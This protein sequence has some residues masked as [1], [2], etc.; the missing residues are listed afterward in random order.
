MS[1]AEQR[2]QTY[3]FRLKQTKNVQRKI[4]EM[5]RNL[6]DWID[7]GEGWQGSECAIQLTGWAKERRCIILRRPTKKTPSEKM[8]PEKSGDEFD[9]IEQV[10]SRELY[11]YAVLIT[12]DEESIVALA[13]L[14]RERADCENVFDEIK[15]QW[16]WGGFMTQDLK[17][18]RIIARLIALVYNWWNIFA[19]LARPDQHMEAITSRPLLL[20]AVG[21]LVKT[22][23]QR[24]LHLTSSHAQANEIRLALNRIGQFFNDLSRTAEQLSAEARW[25]VILSAAF[26]K[27]LRGKILHPVTENDQI[28]LQLSI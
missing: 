24:I 8:L 23:R 7:A 14:Y 27:W 13:Q 10:G 19:R 25:A 28:L 26:I 11:E 22:G 18:C 1:E 9:F 17:R 20:N 4:R 16:G 12:N 5:E 21:R 2:L 15:N 6:E 3:L